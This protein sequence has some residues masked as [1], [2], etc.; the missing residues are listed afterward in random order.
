[1]ILVLD[2]YDFFLMMVPSV[3]VGERK[4]Q[5]LTIAAVAVCLFGV[6]VIVVVN[7]LEDQATDAAGIVMV[8]TFRHLFILITPRCLLVLV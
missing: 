6:I 8:T 5:G 1:M 3:G 2:K 4:I 7:V